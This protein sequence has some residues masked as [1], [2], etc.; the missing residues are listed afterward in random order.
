VADSKRP[1]KNSRRPAR[2]GSL[3]GPSERAKAQLKRSMLSMP[4]LSR[5]VVLGISLLV[6]LAALWLLYSRVYNSPQRVFAAMISNNLSVNGV[7]RV[8]G[9][10]VCLS[11]SA[12]ALNIVEI[13]YFP[14]LQARCITEVNDSTTNPPALVSVESVG[15]KTADYEHYASIHRQGVSPAKYTAAYSIWLKNGVGGSTQQLLVKSLFN[16]V[17][18]GDIQP[19]RRAQI[20]KQL[21][22]AYAVDNSRIQKTR[23][24]G[25]TVYGYN[26]TVNLAKFSRAWNSYIS[27]YGY[28]GAYLIAAGTYTPDKQ[29][30]INIQVDALSR[31]VRAVNFQGVTEAYGAYG[32]SQPLPIP[33]KTYSPKILQNTLNSIK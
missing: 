6:L 29:L 31:Q 11:S 17:L 15:T 4:R 9:Q 33:G 16:P 24:S 20:V 13:N 18:F 14:K 28:G 32:I 12:T 27:Y 2:S 1:S 8:V 22:Q 7:T 19:P 5:P 30:Y 10:P 25:R 23:Q 21:R 3:A 26:V